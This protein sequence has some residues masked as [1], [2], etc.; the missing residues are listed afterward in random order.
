MCRVYH[1]VVTFDEG[2]LR[3]DPCRLPAEGRT[4]RVA[5]QTGRSGQPGANRRVG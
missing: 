3:V 5:A 1:T 2:P 4:A